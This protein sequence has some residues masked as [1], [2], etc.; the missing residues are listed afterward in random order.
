[1]L[2]QEEWVRNRYFFSGNLIISYGVLVLTKWPCQFYQREFP[3][4]MG[5]TL[6]ICETLINQRPLAIATVHLESLNN[7]TYRAEQM[8]IAFE[9]LN[10]Y[11]DAMLMGD[12]NFDS[13]WTKEQ[14]QIDKNFEDVFLALNQGVETFTMPKTPSFA[15]WRPDKILLKKDSPWKAKHISVLGRFSIPSFK[16]EDPMLVI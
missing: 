9:V 11:Q 4:L 16:N 12:F 8:K 7:A 2:F 14:A 5:R 13:S 6:L 1:M 15:A 3:S 10:S